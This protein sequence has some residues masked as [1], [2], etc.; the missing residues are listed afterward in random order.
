MEMIDKSKE[1][2]F[3]WLDQFYMCFYILEIVLKAILLRRSLLCGSLFKVWWNWLDLIIV[4]SGVVDMYLM[5]VFTTL[6]LVT[7][8]GHS[9]KA[10]S[11]LRM[12]RLLRLLKLIK[13]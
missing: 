1:R 7:P 5:P 4:L 8:G 11:F 10:L 12:L 6:G 13:M 9:L 2:T 3:F